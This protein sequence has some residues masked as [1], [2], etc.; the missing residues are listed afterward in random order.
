MVAAALN[1]RRALFAAVACLCWAGWEATGS[2]CAADS[3]EATAADRANAPAEAPEA[4]RKSALATAGVLLLAVV[5][6][7]CVGLLASV[8]LLGARTRRLARQ[9]LPEPCGRDEHWFLRN[10]ISPPEDPADQPDDLDR[11]NASS[12]P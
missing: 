12:R 8:L 9:P 5:I 7:L 1:G 10:K 4:R 3:A 6:V 2:V 11:P